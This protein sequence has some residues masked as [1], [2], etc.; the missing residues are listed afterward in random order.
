GMRLRSAGADLSECEVSSVVQ[1]SP[2]SRAGLRSGD[3]L[4]EVGGKPAA[5]L[6][7]GAILETLKRDGET[8]ALKV[9]RGEETLNVPL[10]LRKLL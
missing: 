7:L 8:V 1:D 5:A 3:R 6:G 9:R 10:P 4:I 2:A